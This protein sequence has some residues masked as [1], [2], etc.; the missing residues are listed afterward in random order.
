MSNVIVERK[1]L[2]TRQALR[3]PLNT[4]KTQEKSI[5]REA[6]IFDLSGVFAVFTSKLT[7]RLELRNLRSTVTCKIQL[8]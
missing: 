4:G 8:E 1:F 6:Y 7:A 3:L 5:A 2:S